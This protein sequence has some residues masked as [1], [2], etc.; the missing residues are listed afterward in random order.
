MN[1]SGEVRSAD[2]KLVGNARITVPRLAP[3]LT[4]LTQTPMRNKA[5][6]KSS[7]PLCMADDLSS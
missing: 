3:S 1:Q 4:K 6:D 5:L 7:L 2:H